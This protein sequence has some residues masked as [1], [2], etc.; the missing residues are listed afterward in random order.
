MTDQKYNQDLDKWMTIYMPTFYINKAFKACA[1]MGKFKKQWGGEN[2]PSLELNKEL[3]PGWQKITVTKDIISD[4]EIHQFKKEIIELLKQTQKN[5]SN[6]NTLQFRESIPD[7]R[8]LRKV[9]IGYLI[10]AYY[11][12]VNATIS[13][14]EK[15]QMD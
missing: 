10:I 15:Y 7:I 11:K 14:F 2:P 8:E 9:M 1:N 5:I 6:T 3:I 12:Q 13:K 4:K